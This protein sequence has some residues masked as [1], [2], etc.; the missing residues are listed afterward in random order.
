MSQ[1][2]EYYDQYSM[3]IQFCYN[4]FYLRGLDI[5]FGTSKVYLDYIDL[6][7]P[8]YDR[9]QLQYQQSQILIGRNYDHKCNLKFRKR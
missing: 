3:N 1:N 2:W 6:H 5:Y 9:Q 7:D 4:V 8:L